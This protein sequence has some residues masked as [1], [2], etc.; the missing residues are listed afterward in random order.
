[1][2]LFP[3]RFAR[4]CVTLFLFGVCL[5]GA[6]VRAA[7][8]IATVA[9]LAPG[10]RGEILTEVDQS[11]NGWSVAIGDADNDGKNEVLTTGC[12]NSRLYLFK[13]SAGAWE[14]RL[15][16][17]DLA[18]RTPGMGLTVRIVD[19]NGDGRNE[20]VLGTGQEMS[21][22]AYFYVAETD[23][24][25]LTRQIFSRPFLKESSYTHSFGICD[26][27]GDGVKEVIAAYCGSGE[28]VRYDMDKDLTKITARTLLKHSGSG[29]DS[30]IADVDNDG[31][32]EYI[33]V[34][35][36]R[37]G[38]ATVEIFDFDAHGELIVPA[39]IVINGFDGKPCFVAGVTVGD[40][41]N[42]GRQD[43]LVGWNRQHKVNKGTVLSYRVE[44]REAKPV[45]TFAYEDPDLDY[46]YFEKMM[47]VADADNDGKN[48]LIV[49]TR[50]EPA[51]TGHADGAGMAHV[52]LYKVEPDAT[53]PTSAVAP[54]ARIARTL[55]VNFHA[56][57]AHS[58][59][60][61]VGD[62]DNDGKNELILATGYGVRM[63]P[64]HSHVVL[65]KKE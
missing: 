14:T 25:R 51:F 1:M 9:Q 18:H 4:L 37:D 21:E 13:K 57:K 41:D 63:Q 48:E 47:V 3:T 19:L 26:L 23:G 6:V 2:L 58:C 20:L 10:W 56:D 49:T 65:V 5:E 7:D 60:P 55:L 43:L 50:G 33:T 46:G 52:F 8:P 35:G 36:Y 53:Q 39:R 62:A 29:E 31:R 42:D 11:Y 54:D 45:Y 34:N 38:K 44:G 12:P 17:E 59:W 16:A 15:L 28:I 24:H 30:C 32:M 27:N 61:A 40:V 64:G 22:P